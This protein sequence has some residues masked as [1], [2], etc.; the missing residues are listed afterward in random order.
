MYNIITIDDPKYPKSL[1]DI[2]DAPKQLYYKGTW[3]EALFNNCLAVVGS[4][5][6]TTY[7]K[8]IT[9]RLVS[10]V[11]SSGIT[12]VSGFMYG[13]D[14]QAHQSCLD[15]GGKT[16]AVMPCGINKI[17]P[18]YHDILYKDILENGGLIISEFEPDEVAQYWTFPRRNRIVAGLSRATMVIEAGE[19]SGSLITAKLAKKYKR[20]VFAVPSPLTSVLSKG[21]SKLIKEGAKIVSSANDIIEFYA[22][23]AR[24]PRPMQGE[25]GETPPL[26]RTTEDLI[27]QELQREPLE[28]DVLSRKLKKPITEL[29]SAISIMQIKGLVKIENNKYYV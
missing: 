8:Q 3:D 9:E 6:M 10:Q 11:A 26:Q 28:M 27:L 13:I 12:I 29:S 17:C 18:E 15:V 25:G 2:S 23:G 19:K 24:L 22:V 4:R 16:I 1:K 14:G 21:T 7:G 5:R 20:A